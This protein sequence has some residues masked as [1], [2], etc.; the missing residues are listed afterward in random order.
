MGAGKDE[1]KK[2]QFEFEKLDVYQKSLVF[3]NRVYEITERFPQLEQ[4]G[5][6]SQFRRAAVSIP[7]NIAEGS[8]DIILRKRSNIIGWQEPQLMNVLQSSKSPK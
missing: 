3:V 8:E 7:L 5:L 2:Q 6:G 1:R 4:F